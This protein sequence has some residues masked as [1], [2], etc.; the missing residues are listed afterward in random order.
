MFSNRDI[1]VDVYKHK[2]VEW[3]TTK[4]N[5]CSQVVESWH[6]MPS[7]VCPKGIYVATLNHKVIGNSNLVCSCKFKFQN[8][9]PCGNY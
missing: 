5:L 3:C 4:F 9:A 6:N 7:W 8:D 1:N 2:I